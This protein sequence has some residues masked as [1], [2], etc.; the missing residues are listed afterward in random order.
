MTEHNTLTGSS[1]HEEKLISSAATSDAGKVVTPSGSVA[2]T[3]ELRKLLTTELDTNSDAEFTLYEADGAGNL[4][5]RSDVGTVFGETRITAGVTATA[6]G[7]SNT[8]TEIN[9]TDVVTGDMSGMTYSSGRIQVDTAGFYRVICHMSFTSAT[10][11]E[12]YEFDISS[13]TTPTL[14]GHSITR[15]VGTGADV[16]ALSFGGIH[17]FAASDTITVYVKNLDS[18]GDPTIERMALNALLLKNV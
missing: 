10:S 8:W 15:K 4:R 14:I 2:N 13:D 12:T 3:G 5:A 6:I 18:A 7:A 11:N 16:G 17:Q 9:L 1:V